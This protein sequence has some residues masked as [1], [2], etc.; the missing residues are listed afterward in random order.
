MSIVP[1]A[2]L[3]NFPKPEGSFFNCVAGLGVGARIRPS[4]RDHS[5]NQMHH[6]PARFPRF[7]R[8]SLAPLRPR[9][10]SRPPRSPRRVSRGGPMN[11]TLTRPPWRSTVTRAPGSA[12]CTALVTARAQ[13]SQVMPSTL[14]SIITPPFSSARLATP[15]VAR[16]WSFAVTDSTPGQ[17]GRACVQQIEISAVRRAASPSSKHWKTSIIPGDSA[18]L[19]GV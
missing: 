1:V 14:R 15:A 4:V 13:P 11:S 16:I 12:R 9:R 6:K 2:H 5:R 18:D 8:R 7:R 19:T 3:A 10:R 17:S